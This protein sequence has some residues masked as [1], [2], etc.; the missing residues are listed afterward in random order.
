M[1]ATVNIS[2][3]KSLYEDAKKIV[4]KKGYSSFSEFI[5]DTLRETLYKEDKNRITENGFPVW[6]ED[7]IL[8]SAASSPENDV[9]LETDKDVREHYK[10]LHKKL[11]EIRHGKN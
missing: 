11:E 4:S 1:I 7:K 2:L 6:F 10:K 9:V 5:R 3:P 8:E